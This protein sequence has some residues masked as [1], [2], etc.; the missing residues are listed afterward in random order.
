MVAS[1]LISHNCS[2]RKKGPR[3]VNLSKA[4][5]T[6]QDYD[7]AIRRITRLYN[8]YLGEN[9][10]VYSVRRAVILRMALS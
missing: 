9:N 3:D 10:D 6:L 7:R 5:K 1:Y 2:R 8:F 4:K